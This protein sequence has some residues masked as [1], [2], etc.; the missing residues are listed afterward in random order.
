MN[1]MA[2]LIA[3][4]VAFIAVQQYFL[5]REKFKLDLFDKRFAIFKA[6]ETFV[7][8]IVGARSSSIE[9]FS[10]WHRQFSLNTQTACFLF[11][12]EIVNFINDLAKKGNRVT[13]AYILKNE[14]QASA[15]ITTVEAL[16]DAKQIQDEFL[17]IQG[18]LRDNFSPYLKFE[19]WKYGVVWRFTK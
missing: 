3:A 10:E 6:T 5:A 11:D 12:E 19:N 14:P 1:Y 18:R 13:V 15:D 9:N 16:K 4:I 17:T 7:D 8:A 2:T